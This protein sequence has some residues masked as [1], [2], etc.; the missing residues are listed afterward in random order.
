MSEL[1]ECIS[2]LTKE[3]DLDPETQILETF[4]K[5]L[6]GALL[7]DGSLFST[8]SYMEKSLRACNIKTQH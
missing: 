4:C 7:N 3:K 2:K 5:E 1:Q 8:T 6:H